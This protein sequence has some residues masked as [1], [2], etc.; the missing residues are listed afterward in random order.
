MKKLFLI[1]LLISLCGC[2]VKEKEEAPLTEKEEEVKETESTDI[3]LSFGS[4]TITYAT[5]SNILED[6]KE[7][8]GQ[9]VKMLGTFRQFYSETYDTYYY[10]CMVT[11]ATAC[12]S[13]GMEFKLKDDSSY[14]L[15]GQQIILQGTVDVY[16]EGDYWYAFLKD[17]DYKIY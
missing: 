2:S 12:C 8:M 15:D 3:D 4:Q 11:D 6:P 13:Q 10:V 7:Y 1:F 17:A 5:I 16:Q 9:R 14:P